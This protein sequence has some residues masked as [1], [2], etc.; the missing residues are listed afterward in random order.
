M[1]S[2]PWYP[3]HRRPAYRPRR[4]RSPLGTTRRGRVQRKS[5]I[6]ASGHHSYPKLCLSGDWLEAAGF[7]LGQS[8]EVD[9]EHGRLVLRA[10]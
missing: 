3:P 2:V 6:L 1:A 7:P 5:R 8:Y 9:V 4:R 10:V